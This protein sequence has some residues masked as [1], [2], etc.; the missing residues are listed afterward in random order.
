MPQNAL[1]ASRKTDNRDVVVVETWLA[2]WECSA[3]NR[4][5]LNQMVWRCDG[6]TAMK[7]GRPPETAAQRDAAAALHTEPRERA[8]GWPSR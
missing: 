5:T 4:I 8:E 1:S 3:L 7:K 6:G 2:S